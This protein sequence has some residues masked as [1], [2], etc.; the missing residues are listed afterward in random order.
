SLFI[1][2][3]VVT[4]FRF[5]LR[6]AQDFYGVD[7]DLITYGKVVGGGMPIGVVSGK[8][9]YMDTF[10]GGQWQ[11]GDGSFPDK[12]VT[13]FAGTFVRH[14][15]AMASVKAMLTFLK[16]QPPFFWKVLGA[17]GDRLATTVDNYFKEHD[18]PFSM[19]NCGS[20]MYVKIEEG[21]TYGSLLFAHM[22]E[23]GVFLLEEFPSYLTAAHTDEDIDYVIAA[24]KESADELMAA[25]FFS[26][27]PTKYATNAPLLSGP[28]S[29]LNGNT[30]IPQFRLNDLTTIEIPTTESQ[31]EILLATQINPETSTAYNESV[32]LILS[33]PLNIPALTEAINLTINRHDALRSRFASDGMTMTIG[34]DI[35]VNVPVLNFTTRSENEKK[36]QVERILLEE[37]DN[38]LDL[39]YGPYIRTRIIAVNALE[40]ILIITAHHIICDGWSID[41]VMRDIGELYTAITDN[42]PINL[43]PAESIINYAR[44]ERHWQTT[45]D[46]KKTEKYWLGQFSDLV[47]SLNF[48][49]D[50]DH[51][52]LKTT[53]GVRIDNLIDP[54]LVKKLRLT[55]AKENC[56]F[57]NILFS[58]FKVYL[59]SQT[60]QQ[61]I[62]VGIPT[63]GQA[64]R[65]MQ[66]LVGHCV[67]LLPI[68]S[69]VDPEL[70]F[71]DY[72]KALQSTML[73][74]FDNSLYTYG[75]LIQ[76]L[77]V[78]R[79][80][81]RVFLTPIVFNFDNGI[82]LSSMK[83]GDLTTEF[84][85]NP[86]THE[87]FEIFLNLTENHNSVTMEWS[88][89]TDLF[90]NETINRHINNFTKLLMK[91]SED[92][93]F[94]IGS[95]V[96]TFDK[97]I[98]RKPLKPQ[99]SIPPVGKRKLNDDASINLVE[100]YLETI[101]I[102]IL[103]IETVNK[104]ADFFEL[105]GHSLLALRLFAQ[106]H[107][108][109][110]VDL[111]ISTL[112][113]NP[114][115]E[116]LSVKICQTLSERDW[117]TA[118]T[119]IL[120]KDFPTKNIN[121]SGN[122]DYWCTTTVIKEEGYKKPIFIVGGLGGNVNNLRDLAIKL[123]DKYPVIGI[124][125]RGILGH[126][127]HTSIEDM[128]AEH[129][130]DIREHQKSGPYY[131]AGYSGGGLTA[132]EIVRQLERE[133]EKIG[134]LGILD[135]VSPNFSPVYDYKLNEYLKHEV[136]ILKEQGF[137]RFWQRATA[138]IRNSLL[139]TLYIR[140]SSK[141]F[142]AHHRIRIMELAWLDAAQNYKGG[143]IS[144]EIN[145]F[146]S[147]PITLADNK[148]FEFDESFGWKNFS[149][150]IVNNI[151]LNG[152]HF[153]ILKDENAAILASHIDEKI[154]MAEEKFGDNNPTEKFE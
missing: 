3:E 123:G 20:L 75:T 30:P 106:I 101:W 153:T 4:G 31:K 131:I 122:D 40:H 26:K 109:Y 143:K 22:R 27:R 87:H 134:L 137:A 34:P 116:K 21:N 7:A 79:D 44:I 115:I 141:F 77:K 112:F 97:V 102:Q 124:Q 120:E 70:S 151:R 148:I 33:G 63:A 83:F 35:E 130:R 55:A 15:L 76:N 117:A 36:A 61:D 5:G 114:T 82:D 64:A 103:G 29:I 19:T 42:K 52:Q 67:N 136:K 154:S 110:S 145:L 93:S 72:M 107:K 99:L 23:K 60:H 48:P 88:Y 56:T 132:F 62:V 69:F 125:T 28:L 2:D 105:G 68:R 89:N 81:S 86:R 111:P 144:S 50:R 53:N 59:S 146:Q 18:L 121:L 104:E 73:E 113:L 152:D 51:P 10:D 150:Q 16:D 127:P 149:E 47:P 80:P 126:T 32:S 57:V 71:I 49:T 128:A 74:A 6:G 41:V 94:D 1:F 118:T 138:K 13:F 38:P 95:Y 12:P 92:P 119:E 147:A 17:K 133:N 140:T 25:G 65:E 90:E 37:V 135:T 100:K 54:R 108:K 84:V 91:I 11:Y 45:K 39:K 66:N 129:I 24:F 85:S 139:G 96:G 98:A 78:T 142:P 8:S 46:Y 14:P 9:K 43:P 58:A